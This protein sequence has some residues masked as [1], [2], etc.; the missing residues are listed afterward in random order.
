MPNCTQDLFILQYVIV[1]L[2]EKKK[3]YKHTEV[4]Y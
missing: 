3:N 2:L 4:Q 1:T